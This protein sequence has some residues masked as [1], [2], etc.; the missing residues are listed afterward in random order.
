MIPLEKAIIVKYEKGDHRFE[1]LVDPE[2]AWEIKEKK[3]IT[4]IGNLDDILASPDVYKDA[5]K[6]ERVSES[7]LKE[8]FNSEDRKYII[9]RIITDGTLH[10][11]TD[12]KRKMQEEKRKQI[13]AIIA[14]Q[15]I[16]PTTNLPHP[17]SR[18]ERAMEEAG[19]HIDPLKPAERQVDEIVNKLRPIIPIKIAR[20]RIEV[21]IPPEHASRVYGYLKQLKPVKTDWKNDGSLEAVIEIPAG[22]QT[23]VFE[24]LNSM[25]HGNVYSKLIQIL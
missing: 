9:F 7:E 16:D 24:K 6:G 22:M 18:I 8:H 5:R 15:A 25:T 10:L 3:D 14:S 4:L 11:T 23:E 20:A 2:K 12:Q 21:R 1:I 17:V 13:V 19:V